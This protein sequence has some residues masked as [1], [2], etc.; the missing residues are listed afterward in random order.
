MEIPAIQKLLNLIE[1]QLNWGEVSGWHSKDFEKLNLLIQDKTKVSLSASTL[2][3]LWGK[4]D[5]S[6]RPSGTTLDT[7]AQFAGYESWRDF[8]KQL[9]IPVVEKIVVKPFKKRMRTSLLGTVALVLITGVMLFL[10]FSYL[11]S[12]DAAI[13]NYSFNS[14]LITRDVPNSVVFTYNAESALTDSVFFQQSWDNNKRSVLDK[15]NHQ[16]TSIYYR[17]GFYLAKL[18]VGQKV[19]K[20]HPIL[21]S[22]NGWLGM[23]AKKPIPVYLNQ[24]E[25]EANAELRITPATI[26]SKGVMLNPDPPRVE[27]Y[28][29]GNFKPAP[30]TDFSFSAEV[31][32]DFQEG[33]AKCGL[34]K[35]I[36]ITD[37]MPVEI[38]LST[39]G[40]IASLNLFDG[41]S[42][43][44]G[45][46]N[47]L[48]GFGADLSKW[49][50]VSCLS[51][52]KKILYFVNSKLVYES[53]L[54]E[55]KRNILGIGF[56]FQGAGAAKNVK[57]NSGKTTD[58]SL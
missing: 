22:T 39:P 42:M 14:R 49:V 25:F 13:T 18:V 50:K 3:R 44:S 41:L 23:I 19:V 47:D 53:K 51:R 28:N 35:I 7:L 5:Y 2:R 16:Y 15:R 46:S 20:E 30:L 29:V 24:K 55:V 26:K 31:R 36:L 32:N 17:P 8:T 40:C 57:L 54:P 6:H 58:F 48:S 21:I 12:T 52:D 10:L 1:Q 37:E 56:K 45:K 11:K 43:I 33:A 38:A 27:F 4:V 34:V 9:E